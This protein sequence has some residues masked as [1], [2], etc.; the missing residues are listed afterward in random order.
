MDSAGAGPA[1]T[2]DKASFRA[3]ALAA[4]R[5]RTA[6]ELAAQRAALREIVLRR[7]TQAGWR[8]VAGYEPL[9][10]EP[11]SV[12]LLAGWHG[13]GISVLVPVLLPDRDLDWAHWHPDPDRPRPVL[14]P[15]S[16]SRAEAVFVP[17]LAVARDGTRLG[18]GGG[19][20]DR[21]LARVGDAPV[22]ALLFDGELAQTLPR[23]EW[24]RPVTAVVTPSGWTD[25]A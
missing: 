3:A 13:L 17:A 23:D 22:V 8:C 21:A 9:R 25:L 18:R 7:C 12:E 1:G 16:I 4:R 6:A 15:G 14:G 19:S 20:Y 24:D 10:T 2:A 5:E 11:G